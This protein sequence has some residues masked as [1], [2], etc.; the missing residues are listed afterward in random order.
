MVAAFS[1]EVKPLLR[2]QRGVRQ[3]DGRLYSFWLG[4]EPVLL[5]VGGMGRENSLR[6]AESLCRRGALRGLVAL[7][8]AGALVDSL[9]PGDV[10]LADCLVDQQSG[11]EF[12]CSGSFLPIQAVQGV[13]RGRMVTVRS[14]VTSPEEKRRLAESWRAEAVDMESTGVARVAAQAGI[15]FCAIRSITDSCKQ[16]IF[17]D[18]EQ[19]RREDGGV[20]ILRMVREGLRSSQG[21]RS[22]WELAQGAR[23]AARNLAEVISSA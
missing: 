10:I 8:F 23:L 6:A 9:S 20:S 14:V 17:I 2:K 22:I 21:V 11:E 1:W 18:F 16:G 12:L 15:P 4:G 5:A 19:C 3:S 13:G 7:G